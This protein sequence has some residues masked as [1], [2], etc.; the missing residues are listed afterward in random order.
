MPRRCAPDTTL[1]DTRA[2]SVPGISGAAERL[3]IWTRPCSTM[4]GSRCTRLAPQTVRRRVHPRTVRLPCRFARTCRTTC[5]PRRG[6][7]SPTTLSPSR[8]RP[9]RWT[10]RSTTALMAGTTGWWPRPAAASSTRGTACAPRPRSAGTKGWWPRRSQTMIV[11][12]NF[13]RRQLV[14][15]ITAIGQTGW[16]RTGHWH[17]RSPM[18]GSKFCAGSLIRRSRGRRPL[19]PPKSPSGKGSG[20]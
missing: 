13:H 9:L 11:W 14:G 19:L 3:Q 12:S 16:A 18:A 7:R 1:I 10:P 5:P 8:T 15:Y 2:C 20:F 17:G 4:E 6:R